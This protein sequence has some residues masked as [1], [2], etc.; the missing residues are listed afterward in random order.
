MK[1]SVEV[2]WFHAGSVSADVWSW[3]AGGAY[4]PLRQ[5]PRID[6]YLRLAKGKRLGIKL[7]EGLLEVKQRTRTYGRVEFHPHAVGRVEA[8]RKWSFPLAG[9]GQTLDSLGIQTPAWIAV[10]KQRD[11]RIYRVGPGDRVSAL[12]SGNW[13]M[14]GCALELCAVQAGGSLW[15]TLGFE[16]FGPKATLES[17]LRLVAVHVLGGRWVPKLAEDD[18]F[19]YP[20]WLAM[21]AARQ[22]SEP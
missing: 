10:S 17:N 13:S 6:R 20:A 16:A 2:R 7:R 5:A 19:G 22:D 1:A 3:F 8:W 14:Q 18:S 4:P 11:L 15:W 12:P 21:L 9:G